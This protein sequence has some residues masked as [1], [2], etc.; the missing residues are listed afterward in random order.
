MRRGIFLV[1]RRCGSDGCAD[2]LLCDYGVDEHAL[3]Q[4]GEGEAAEDDRGEGVD[5][6]G[7]AEGEGCV[8][9]FDGQGECF[10]H[11]Y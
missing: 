8:C 11:L 2:G 10:L 7:C 6:G 4:A 3:E 9:G 5:G 1:K